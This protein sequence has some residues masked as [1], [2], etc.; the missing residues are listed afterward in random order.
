LIRPLS[1]RELEVLQLIAEG[2]SNREIAN[3]LVLSP[4]TVKVHTRSIYRKLDVNS[5]TQAVGRARS[6]DL[7]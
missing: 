4:S 2:H 6:L 7:L 3:I 1:P 5:R